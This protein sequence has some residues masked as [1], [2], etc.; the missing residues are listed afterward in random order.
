MRDKILNCL[1]ATSSFGDFLPAEE[2]FSVAKLFLNND[3][4]SC[5]N[6]ANIYVV[7]GRDL[8]FRASGQGMQPRSTVYGVSGFSLFYGQM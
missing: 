2:K 4:S 6:S 3:S 1:Y 8:C 5:K 7:Y